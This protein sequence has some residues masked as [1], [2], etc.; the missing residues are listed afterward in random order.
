MTT[1]LKKYVSGYHE[2]GGIREVLTLTLPMIISVS[3]HWMLIP[4][5]YLSMYVLKLSAIRLYPE[6]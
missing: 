1:F 2:P 3:A 5:L 6:D 4:V